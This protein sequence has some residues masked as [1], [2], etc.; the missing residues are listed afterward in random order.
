[1][2]ISSEKAACEV[3]LEIHV[4]KLPEKND[5]DKAHKDTAQITKIIFLG[6]ST[7]N[8]TQ[9]IVASRTELVSENLIPYLSPS[10]PKGTSVINF[11]VS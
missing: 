10:T 9:V 6:T 4:S 1:M 5:S 11:T 3:S 7:K 2:Y 8:I